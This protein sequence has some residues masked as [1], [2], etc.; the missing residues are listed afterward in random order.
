MAAI[1]H[2][3][4]KSPVGWIQNPCWIVG[5]QLLDYPVRVYTENWSTVTTVDS[6][7]HQRIVTVTTR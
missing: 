2:M 7:D 3:A 6:V 4:G 5:C 1:S